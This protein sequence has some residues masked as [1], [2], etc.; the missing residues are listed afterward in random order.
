MYVCLFIIILLLNFA[1]STEQLT[2]EISISIDDG[3][4][5]E[6]NTEQVCVYNNVCVNIGLSVYIVIVL[7]I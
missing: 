6:A 1:G 2:F 5:F 4:C 7:L 3:N